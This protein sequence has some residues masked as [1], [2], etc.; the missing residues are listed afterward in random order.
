MAHGGMSPRGGLSGVSADADAR[1]EGEP[2]PSTGPSGDASSG[3]RVTLADSTRAHVLRAF[4][5]E[6]R[7]RRVSRGETAPSSVDAL[8]DS[9]ESARRET[10]SLARAGEGLPRA[11]ATTSSRSGAPRNARS[12]SDRDPRRRATTTTRRSPL[13]RNAKRAAARS[14]STRERR[15]FGWSTQCPFGSFFS[16]RFCW[17]ASRRSPRSRGPPR[18]FRKRTT[19]CG[20]RSRFS[21]AT[22]RLRLRRA[23]RTRR[24]RVARN[25]NGGMSRTMALRARATL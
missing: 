21:S 16:S 12:G 18:R 10:S 23:G 13:P 8:L 6:H 19:A 15:R 3:V 11:S 2:A 24:T 4:L 22:T 17:I 20:E 7:E 1:W 25:D 5:R 14:T 9:M